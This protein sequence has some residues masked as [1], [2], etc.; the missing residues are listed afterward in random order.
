MDA[1]CTE[2]T[3]TRPDITLVLG[4]LDDERRP[5][6]EEQLDAADARLTGLTATLTERSG[7]ESWETP[8]V[9]VERYDSGQAMIKGIVRDT[10]VEIEFNVELRPGNFFDEARPWRP[11]EPPRHMATT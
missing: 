10:E 7:R 4:E 11:G 9:L 6:I 1:E 5:A 2:A 8:G 3:E